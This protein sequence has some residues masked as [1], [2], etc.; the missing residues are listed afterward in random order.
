MDVNAWTN[1]S[2]KR[3]GVFMESVCSSQ[4]VAILRSPGNRGG[5]RVVLII[6][7]RHFACLVPPDESVRQSCGQIV[8]D[9]T[10]SCSAK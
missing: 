1:T 2:D 8:P 6:G 9:Q 3:K 4:V 5:I 7:D 10:E